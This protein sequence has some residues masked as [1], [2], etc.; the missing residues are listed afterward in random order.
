MKKGG[1]FSLLV[2][3]AGIAGAVLRRLERQTG[4]EPETG[5]AISGNVFAICLIGLSGA[6][7]LFLLFVMLCIRHQ[8]LFW[9]DRASLTESPVFFA[10]YCVAAALVAIGGVLFVGKAIAGPGVLTT[11]LILGLFAIG[12]GLSL[13][14]TAKGNYGQREKG[15]YRL[16]L[17]IPP[18]FCCYW[19]ILAYEGH[20]AN[21]VVLQYVYE[22]FAI[23]CGVLAFYFISTFDYGQAKVKPA[24]LFGWMA[25]YFSIVTLADGHGPET[26]LL[27]IGFTLYLLVYLAS[28]FRRAEW[29]GLL[30]CRLG[31]KR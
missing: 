29:E 30:T 3:V 24:L 23:I 12:A 7:F 25:C 4:F 17:L 1:F 6:V 31:K 22:L 28:F 8:P 14:W 21:P 19:L 5:L 10:L 20:A 11:K 26:M 15:R 27:Y 9:Y 13:A 16:R 18:F 2:L